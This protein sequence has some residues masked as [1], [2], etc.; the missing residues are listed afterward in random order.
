MSSYVASHEVAYTVMMVQ[1]LT[2][3]ISMSCVI[4]QETVKLLM[5]SVA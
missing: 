5:G 2:H 1:K 4:A 3:T